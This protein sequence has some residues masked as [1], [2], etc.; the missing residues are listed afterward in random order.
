MTALAAGMYVGR[1]PLQSAGR[2]ELLRMVFIIAIVTLSR[3]LHLAN[4]DVN[5]A[6]LADEF[7]GS[8]AYLSPPFHRR[9]LLAARIVSFALHFT[10]SRVRAI[11]S[12]PGVPLMVAA[13]KLSQVLIVGF[14]VSLP[15]CVTLGHRIVVRYTFVPYAL[16][17]LELSTGPDNRGN[18][19]TRHLGYL[20]NHKQTSNTRK[21][22]LKIYN[23]KLKNNSHAWSPT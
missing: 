17:V 15:A 11:V 12:D 18:L 14:D 13:H 16:A 23:Y 10:A 21:M 8:N 3:V 20:T 9:N 4:Y 7:T 6:A 22:E 2:R 19:T 1:L 5:V